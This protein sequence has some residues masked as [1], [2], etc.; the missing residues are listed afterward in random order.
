M[1]DLEV[2]LLE[3]EIAE[4]F[5]AEIKK[6]FRRGDEK[7]IKVAEFRRLEQGEKIIEEFVQE[8]KRAV[9][10]SRYEERLLVEKFKR[11]I[12]TIIY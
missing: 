6:E 1:E 4:E 5:L 11:R 10:G 3:Y 9:R 8:F 7:S 2:G 12:N